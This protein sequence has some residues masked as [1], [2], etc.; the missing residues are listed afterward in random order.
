MARQKLSPSQM[1]GI[2][3]AAVIL[4]PLFT[5]ISEP[6]VIK[7]LYVIVTHNAA[8]WVVLF[9][10]LIFG[11]YRKITN[12]F[13]F[14]WLEFPVQVLASIAGIFILYSVFFFTTSDIADRE[15]WNSYITK[16]EYYEEWTEEVEYEDCD[17]EGKNCVTKT[18]EVY[19][20]PEWYIYSN[21][22]EQQSINR[23]IYKTYVREF[24]NEDKKL[25]FRANQVSIGDGNM[26]KT[27]FKS[28]YDKRITS[29]IE[30]DYINYVK[31]TE[32]LHKRS[33]GNTVGFE[34]VLLNYPSTFSNSFGK[35]N[36]NRV[37]VAGGLNVD[38]DWLQK[39]DRSLD[40]VLS[41]LGSKKQVNI[42]IYLVKSSDQSFIH[43]LEE[44]WI[45]G[46]KNDVIVVVGM[47][48]Y[49]KVEWVSIM[50]WTKVEEFKI[51]LR[52]NIVS[53]GDISDSKKFV[54][55][56]VNQVSKPGDKGGY[57]RMPMS[58]L[59]YLVSDITIPWWASILV[60]LFSA[61]LS[62]AT[63]WALINNEIQN[64]RRRWL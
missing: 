9:I 36:L 20:P 52:D 55:T 24:G 23:S 61:L 15:V 14:T 39:V 22:G 28:T 11:F 51:E 4:V 26:Y 35:I 44:H 19:H 58:D 49:P 18:R 3:V 63:S 1:V 48:E 50:A 34:K 29:A 56:I 60:I 64:W 32:T 37:L 7:K 27:E 33:G 42:L 38:S 43:A 12:P 57:V 30:H 31:G 53:M 40:L 46:K 6:G 5:I 16:S 41:D 10:A 21:I 25:L 45:N 59:E 2:A 8:F 17:S 47:N 54:D 13:K 62:W